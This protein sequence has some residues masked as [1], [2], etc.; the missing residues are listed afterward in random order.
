[1]LKSYFTIAWR[2]IA[3]HKAYTFINVAGLAL[4]ICSCIVIYLITSY[5]FSFDKFHPDKDRIYRIVGNMQRS[6]GETEFLN[7]PFGDVAGFKDQIPGF[8]A[9]AGFITYGGSISIPNGKEPPKKF[10]N[11]IQGS[12][13][14]TSIITWPQYFD[15]FKYKWLAGNPQ[16]LNNPF[17][18]VLSEKRAKEY[19]GDLPLNELIGKT[20]VYD[21][22]LKVTVSGIV[23]DWTR[24]TDLGY[25]DFISISTATHSFLKNQIP[26]ED[27]TSLQPHNAMAF[28]KLIKGVTPDQVNS[29]F[30]AYIRDHVKMPTGAKLTMYLQPLNDI[31]FSAEFRRSDDGDDF[32]KAYRPTLYVLMGVAIFILLIAA[33]NF[34]NLSTAQSIQRAKE[35]GVRKV[36]GSNKKKIMLQFL[37]ETFVLTFFAVIVSMLLVDPMLYLFKDYIPEAV[38][39]HPFNASTLIFLLVVT[40]LTT[41]LAG[42]YPA[43]VLAGY[44]PVLSLKGTAVQ[45]NSEKLNLRKALIVFQ[46]TISLVFIIGA[47][48]MVK[49]IKFMTSADKGFNTDAIITVNKWRDNNGNLKVLAENIKHIKGV[50]KVLLQ[51]FPPMGFAQMNSSYIYKGKENINLQP[52]LEIGNEDYIPLYQMKLIAGRNILHSDSLNE[53]VVNE[54]LTKAIGCKDP[55]DAVGKMLYSQGSQPDK[56]FPIVGVVSDFHQGSFHDAIQPAVIGNVPSYHSIAVKLTASEKNVTAVKAIITQIETQW[57]KLYPDEPLD[58]SFLNESIGW[59]YGQDEKTAWLVNAAMIITI[60]ISCM[61]LF[62]LGMF[63]AQRRTKEIGIRKVL[64]ASVSDIAVMLSKD[65]LIL[66][67]LA[68]LVASPIAYYFSHQWLKD[69]VYR[70]NISFWIFLLAGSAIIVVALLT[71]SFQAFKAAIANPVTNLRTE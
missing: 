63:T 18:V 57:K 68:F 8:E 48:V 43:K 26:A 55:H 31:H 36:L 10:D 5:E 61:G 69:F 66:V 65:F 28:V 44:L 13:S 29:R 53:I 27:W 51:G 46:F 24:N 58:Y 52:I 21:D 67:L 7:T 50:D 33:V 22:S 38:T 62:G 23:K 40:I 34:V 70:T 39:F 12:Y 9:K 64:G 42:F 54:T 20:V 3:K 14:S 35:I 6:S 32:R 56:A 60:F 15:I 41:V 4:G 37:T 17:K 49:Q 30:A 2:N 47:I 19:F 25:T 59:L 11:R 45:T 71:V 16:T 1:M